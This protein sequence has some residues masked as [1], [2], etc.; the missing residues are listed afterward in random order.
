MEVGREIL[1]LSG[2][3]CKGGFTIEPV[4][5]HKRRR[6]SRTGMDV[7]PRQYED[8]VSSMN[9]SFVC[10]SVSGMESRLQSSAVF[11][12]VHCVWVD[13]EALSLR[14]LILLPPATIIMGS[15]VLSVLGRAVH[16]SGTETL[17]MLFSLFV[18][19]Y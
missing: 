8:M 18:W 9:H 12:F 14:I 1:G 10:V 5:P 6:K 17:F 7:D 16:R 2:G 4:R 13:K 11:K 3:I 19:V 15:C